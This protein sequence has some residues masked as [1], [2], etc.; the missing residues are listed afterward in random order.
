MAS[1]WSTLTSPKTAVWN[2]C[3]IAFPQQSSLVKDQRL[4]Q[5][6]R[7]NIFAH[8]AETWHLSFTEMHGEKE[9]GVSCFVQQTHTNI[10]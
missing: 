9:G 3:Q 6:I 10:V 5:M 2:S 4:L 1:R 8:F 7:N